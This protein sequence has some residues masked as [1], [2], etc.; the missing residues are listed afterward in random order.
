MGTYSLVRYAGGKAKVY[1]FIK[2]LIEV[3]GSTTYIQPFASD[4]SIAIPYYFTMM[5]KK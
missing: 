3:N 2:H 1:N 5:L 4:T